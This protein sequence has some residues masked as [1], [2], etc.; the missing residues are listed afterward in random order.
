M[1]TVMQTMVVP[2]LEKHSPAGTLWV[3]D[4]DRVRVRTGAAGTGRRKSAPRR[5]PKKRRGH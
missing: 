4:E 5:G 1:V 3:V 2:L